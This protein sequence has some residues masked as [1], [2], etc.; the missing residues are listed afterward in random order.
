[1]ASLEPAA[2]VL[3]CGGVLGEGQLAR[4]LI[5]SRGE[6]LLNPRAV[7]ILNSLELEPDEHTSN[8]STQKTE[9]EGS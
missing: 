9:A 2:L 5:Q 4:A 8:P 7:R 1:M 3:G 6:R